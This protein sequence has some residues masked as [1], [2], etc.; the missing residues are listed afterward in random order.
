MQPQFEV[1]PL[2]S[3]RIHSSGMRT[4]RLL[5]VSQHALYRGVCIP[6]Y[7]GQGGVCPGESTWGDRPEGGVSALGESALGGVCLR[8]VCP[9]GGV[10]QHT[11]G[12]TPL[13]P[14]GQTPVKTQTSFAGGNENRIAGV[15]AQ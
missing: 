4:A 12:Q 13:P 15:I 5:T 6:V 8:G 3:T 11:I 2:F 14:C 9:R 7:T 10:S 1:N